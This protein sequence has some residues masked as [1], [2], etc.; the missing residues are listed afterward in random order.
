[1]LI[2]QYWIDALPFASKEEALA[3]IEEFELTAPHDVCLLH[4]FS[5]DGIFVRVFDYEAGTSGWLTT[6]LFQGFG[7]ALARPVVSDVNQQPRQLAVAHDL[8]V[9]CQHRWRV[10]CR[11]STE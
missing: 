4:P 9:R 6:E 7:M 5:R 10:G 1:M 11:W 8:R 3:A 2:T